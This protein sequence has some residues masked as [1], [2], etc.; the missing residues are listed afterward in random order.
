M[1]KLSL[2]FCPRRFFLLSRAYRTIKNL[3]DFCI[4][5]TAEILFSATTLKKGRSHGSSVIFVE[6]FTFYSNKALKIA[7]V[8]TSVLV[9]IVQSV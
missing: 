4:E 9:I 6:H 1:E 3:S 5:L 2:E 8:A 7:H